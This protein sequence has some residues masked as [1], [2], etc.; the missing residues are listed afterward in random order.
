MN[1]PSF[2]GRS[3]GGVIDA[4]VAGTWH[5][6]ATGKPASVPN[7]SIVIAATLEGAEADL[8]APLHRGQ[9]LTVVADPITC[10]VLGRRV[11][12]ALRATLPVELLVWQKP[13]CSDE[14]IAELRD[15]TRSADG[16]IAVGAG[17]VS[18]SVKYASFLDHKPYSVFATSP[19]N[20]YTTPTASVSFAGFK[21]STPAH[22][23]RGVFFDLAI[24]AQCPPR[25]ITAAFADLIC[26]T[27]AQVDWLLSH[28]LLGTR[29]DDT[30]YALLAYDEDRLLDQAARYQTGEVEALAVLTRSAAIMG[31]GTSFTGTTHS[32]SMAEH[33]M[34]HFIDMFAGDAHPGTS[35]GEQ[36]GVATLT[37]STLQ[38]LIL[39]A[40]EPPV[41][42]P[43]S[44][45]YER[46]LS[47][48]GAEMA[49]EMTRQL[50][51]KA[52]N[53]I[54]IDRINRRLAD[55]WPAFV[56]P[57]RAA[58][59]PVQRLWDAMTL[60]GA[61]RT[62]AELGLEADLY[63]EAVRDARFTRDR[64]TILD[65]AASA[66]LLDAFAAGAG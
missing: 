37:V 6:P 50:A 29:Y 57:L 43:L 38:N 63:R 49:G 31:L 3:H 42:Q 47:R 35:H 28:L 7:D 56:A 8:V 59:L 62:A 41:L 51:A 14:G 12:E 60:A 15:L 52:L 54:A 19:M 32:G 34:S 26:R 21:R 53:A 18:D 13:R 20:A 5:H 65:L 40:A 64:F 23:A 17:T 44:E 9:G 30:A 48:F 1:G 36:V 22:A 4:L 61:P 10:E 58:M 24:L 2:T 33:M 66:G 16:L 27:T 46:L 39:G 11:H 45:P 55:D 25:L